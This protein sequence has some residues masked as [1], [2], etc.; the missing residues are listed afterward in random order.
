MSLGDIVSICTLAGMAVS[1]L[2]AAVRYG[3]DQQKL[4]SENESQDQAFTATQKEWQTQK[5]M[6]LQRLQHLEEK[7]ASENER[8]FR[9]HDEFYTTEKKV[10]EVNA[11]LKQLMDGQEEIKKGLDRLATRIDTLDRRG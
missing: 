10:I 11:L 3:A 5:E 4:H 2:V 7:F 8:N 1:I 9:Q 6:V